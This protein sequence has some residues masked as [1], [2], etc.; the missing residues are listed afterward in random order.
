MFLDTNVLISILSHTP[1][2]LLLEKVDP[3]IRKQEAYISDIVLIEFLSWPKFS[4][5]DKL[6]VH[7]IFVALR[8]IFKVVRIKKSIIIKTAEIRR[9]YKKV[10]LPD[11][12]IAATAISYGMEL[13]TFNTEDFEQI[14]ELKLVDNHEFRR[15]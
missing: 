2:K 6:D 15:I 8:N 12:V 13:L 9:K 10:K 1:D 7:K 4:E 14:S 11:A 5:F 3:Y